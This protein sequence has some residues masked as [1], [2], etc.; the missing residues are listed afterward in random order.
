M[1][2]I[3]LVAVYHGEHRYSPPFL[4]DSARL[5][6]HR[7]RPDFS[8]T[9]FG[10]TDNINYVTLGLAAHLD[11]ATREGHLQWC[12][13]WRCDYHVLPLIFGVDGL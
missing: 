7:T 9:F 5:C 6:V 2:A 8:R 1:L 3:S 13:T 10:L 11:G 4:I 12:R